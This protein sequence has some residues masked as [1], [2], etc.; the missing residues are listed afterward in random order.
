M[1]YTLSNG[2][3]THTGTGQRMHRENQAV[4]TAV[5]DKDL[6]SVTWSMMEII[7]EAGLAGVQFDPDIPA[8]Y[9]VLL[10][11]IN[12]LIGA[13]SSDGPGRVSIFLQPDPPPKHMRI[14]GVLL[15]RTAFP[16]LWEHVQAVGAVTEAEWFA[17]RWGWFSSGD[18]STTFRIPLVGGE[19][20]RFLDGGRGVDI[21]RLIGSWQG[22]ANQ[23]HGHDTIQTPHG[24]IIIESPHAHTGATNVAGGH[25]HG[26][27]RV[28]EQ[29]ADTDRGT[30]SS[31]FSLDNLVNLPTDGA[32]QHEFVTN[33]QTT[34]ATI[35]PQ[36]ANISIA[37]QGS[38]ARMRNIAWP[39]YLKYEW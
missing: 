27:T 14:N 25:N 13:A 1:D 31:A 7:K 8:T 39:V 19:A 10:Q 12:K 30:T 36:L 37:S 29:L 26:G 22:G 9:R 3:F 20:L 5:S 24:H 33:G 11:A 18:G 32:H 17:D 6:N 4:P 35:Q 38:E 23:A 15:S 34:G 16:E 2:Y 28:P 21:G